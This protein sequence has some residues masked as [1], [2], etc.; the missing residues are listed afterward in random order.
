MTPDT[1]THD[2]IRR[3]LARQ[4]RY[5][6]LLLTRCFRAA[7]NPQVLLLAAI[8]AIATTA[9]WRLAD[10]ALLTPAEKVEVSQV[11]DD[12]AFYNKWPGQRL[13]G[14]SPIRWQPIIS[15]ESE[16]GPPP[17]DP[18]MALPYRVVGAAR[19][20]MNHRNSW[21]VMFYYLFGGLWTVLVWSG[22]GGAIS[23]M[24]ARRYTRDDVLSVVEAMSFSQR[25][26]PSFFGGATGP[27]L[28]V[29]VLAI[30]VMAVGLLM[31]TDIGAAIVGLLWIFTIPLGLIM[32]I[33]LLGLLFGWP[34]VWG[35]IAVESSD[36]FDAVSRTYSYTFQRPLHYLGYTMVAG[37]LGMLGWLVVWIAS[38]MLTDVS[39]WAAGLTAGHD[40]IAE[41]LAAPANIDSTRSLTVAGSVITFWNGLIRTLASAFGYSYFWCSAVAVYLLL[42]KQVDGVELDE[43]TSESAQTYGLPK[44]STDEQGVPN[45]IEAKKAAGD[46]AAD[47]GVSDES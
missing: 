20:F 36:A 39:L 32:A 3:E 4:E 37:V 24:A 41:I 33:I 15:V 9:G 30:P 28:G 16:F 12:S 26:L 7:T 22:F 34:L 5:P 17:D 42:R 11:D 43:I 25:K 46:Q 1:A 13:K 6:W 31:R 2:E 40:R 23:R 38:E 35:A 29:A 44:L 18:L 45:V 10:R 14:I 27:M 8:G 19:G 47:G 21:S